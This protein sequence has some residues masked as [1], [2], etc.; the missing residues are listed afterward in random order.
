MRSDYLEYL[1]DRKKEVNAETFKQ[2]KSIRKAEFPRKRQRIKQL[3][4]EAKEKGLSK[5]E[6][7]VYVN[8]AIY[9][10]PA[11]FSPFYFIVI[12]AIISWLVKRFLD[13]HYG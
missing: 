2:E 3:I 11:T 13:K 12:R 6:A 9:D 5:E 1:R 7:R 8:K 10:E 4:T